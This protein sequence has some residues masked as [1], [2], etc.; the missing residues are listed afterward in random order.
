M[1]M[2]VL[3]AEGITPGCSTGVW[4][5]LVCLGNKRVVEKELKGSAAASEHG[6]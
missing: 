2:Q 1:H 5:H 3:T 6:K 4:K